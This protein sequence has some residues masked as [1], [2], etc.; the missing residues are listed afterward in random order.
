MPSHETQMLKQALGSATG[1]SA[2]FDLPPE[3]LQKAR[4]RLGFL[5]GI[6]TIMALIGF[7]TQ[8][9]LT[10]PTE[11]SSKIIISVFVANIATSVGLL[12]ACR[13]QRLS[14]GLVLKLGLAYE[15]LTCLVVSIFVTWGMLLKYGQVPGLTWV[16]ILIV[17]FPILIPSRPVTTLAVSLLSAATVPVGLLVLQLNGAVHIKYLDYIGL[18][19]SPL[20]C[21]LL[22][23]GASRVIYGLSRDMA[24]AQQLGAYQ[25]EERLGQGGMGE[26][27]RANHQMLAR[28]AAV[29]LINPESLAAD[30]ESAEG[31]IKRFER[32][33]QATAA[34]QSE[35]T[36]HIH[37]YGVNDDG[38]CYYVMELLDG[39]DLDAL[40]TRYGPVRPERAVHIL[41]QACHSLAEAHSGGLI[42]RDIKP[43]NIYLCRKG[44][45]LDYVKVLDF[46]LVKRTT[47]LGTSSAALTMEG[48]ITGTPA[49]MAPEMAV[50][51]PDVDGRA[52]L[53]ALGCVAYWLLSGHLVF[54]GDNAMQIIMAH[55]KDEPPELTKRVE[56]EL[57]DG[58][59][60]LVHACLAK[61][62][63]D[64]PQ[65]AQDLADRLADLS[66]DE[67]WSQANARRWWNTHHPG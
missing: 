9:I 38:I 61:D 41:H 49:F 39:M 55:A 36:V 30:S 67:P 27:W 35:H 19:I 50:G 59:A 10:D 23:V 32:E 22:A 12:A 58:L 7:V 11:R 56:L 52:D 21:V 18:T 42:H 66:L 26:V 15:V 4:H 31:A 44:L 51:S 8:F 25:L 33:A 47:D 3:L 28:P 53:Y 63:G 29:K 14:H 54:E 37:D 5:A 20:L 16:C 60:D 65:S 62:P 6:F 48:N 17:V 46:G 40:V 57:P 34:L 64:R 45:D 2:L 43:A 24:R 13:L 1:R